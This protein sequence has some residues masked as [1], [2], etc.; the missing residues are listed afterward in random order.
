MKSPPTPPA[1][2]QT[3]RK[4]CSS[5]NALDLASVAVAR[6]YIRQAITPAD[7]ASMCRRIFVR[8]ADAA[9]RPQPVGF[10]SNSSILSVVF[11]A[12]ALPFRRAPR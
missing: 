5:N 12:S 3:M 7:K 10:S 4:Y 9:D 8:Q 1:N 6:S 11:A 2:P